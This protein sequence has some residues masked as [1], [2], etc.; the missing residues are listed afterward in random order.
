MGGGG[1]GGIL[2]TFNGQPSHS[3]L[4]HEDEG[5]CVWA[6]QSTDNCSTNH[7]RRK[8]GYKRALH[9]LRGQR[10]SGTWSSSERV[11]EASKAGRR[12]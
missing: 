1:G 7:R 2:I 10:A 3:V 4:S 5:C 6:N 11:T 9:T 8:T 12:A